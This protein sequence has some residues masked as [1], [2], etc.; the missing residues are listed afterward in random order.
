M[1]DDPDGVLLKI[2]TS[3][4]NKVR[5]GETCWLWSGAV[6]NTGMPMMRDPRS[7]KIVS[8]RR[9]V[10]EV[11]C[12]KFLRLYFVRSRCGNKLCVNPRHLFLASSCRK[13]PKMLAEKPRHRS[14]L[15]DRTEEDVARKFWSMVSMKSTNECW[16]WAPESRRVCDDNLKYRRRP[17]FSS[18]LFGRYRRA[19]RIAYLLFYGYLSDDL[20]VCHR[21]DNDSCVNPYHLFLGTPKDN[22][23]D[24]LN[25][26]RG[27]STLNPVQVRR[28]RSELGVDSSLRRRKELCLEYRVSLSALYCLWR[29]RTYGWVA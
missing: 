15:D 9:L 19:S 7:V 28:I 12:G 2:K 18:N 29:G 8:A 14:V 22:A 20:D 3:L 17:Y 24:M 25:K 5:V 16:E 6:N 11:Y 4:L 21:C 26:G 13:H 1:F 23:L 10:Y 27:K